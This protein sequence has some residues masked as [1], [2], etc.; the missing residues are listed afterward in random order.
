MQLPAQHQSLVPVI[1]NNLKELNSP[2][3][4][5]TLLSVNA[6]LLD[7][8]FLSQIK[9]MVTT[10]DKL[11]YTRLGETSSHGHKRVNY[12]CTFHTFSFLQNTEIWKLIVAL[13][14][15]TCKSNEI[16]KL[17][18]KQVSQLNLHSL[19]YWLHE[20]IQC[21]NISFLSEGLYLTTQVNS[22]KCN[23]NITL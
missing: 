15:S 7:C 13:Y 2:R 17:I 8:F 14:I 11:R 9:P 5:W 23:L 20:C 18:Q 16:K 22:K 10:S 4:S 21:Y 19:M 12:Q 1:L 6:F 3:M